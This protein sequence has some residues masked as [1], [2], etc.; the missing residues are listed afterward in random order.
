[1]KRVEC[2]THP[3]L[4]H[5]MKILPI[6]RNKHMINHHF[7]FLAVRL[8]IYSVLIYYEISYEIVCSIYWQSLL[9]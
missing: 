2:R 4:I 3:A 1:M 9:P 8:F 7:I 6:S 5:R